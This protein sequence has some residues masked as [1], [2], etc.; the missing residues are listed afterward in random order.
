MR[1][2]CLGDS[3]TIGEGVAAHERWPA[4][5]AAMLAAEGTDTA[6]PEIVEDLAER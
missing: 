4:R 3:Y 1:I 5:V 6:E 2:L